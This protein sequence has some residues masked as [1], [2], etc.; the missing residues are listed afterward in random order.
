MRVVIKD[1]IF[2]GLDTYVMGTLSGTRY[3]D[4]REDQGGFEPDEDDP[5]KLTWYDGQEFSELDWDNWGDYCFEW[6]LDHGKEEEDD[7][8]TEEN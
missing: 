3:P 6:L 4:T 2:V 5:M 1:K 8:M 7:D